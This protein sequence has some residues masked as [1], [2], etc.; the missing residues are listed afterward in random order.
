MQMCACLKDHIRVDYVF[1]ALC[2][3]CARSA[4]S[5]NRQDRNWQSMQRVQNTSV[6]WHWSVF[7][8]S[9]TNVVFQT[10]IFLIL[11]VRNNKRSSG[12]DGKTSDCLSRNCLYHCYLELRFCFNCSLHRLNLWLLFF[13]WFPHGKSAACKKLPD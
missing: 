11:V 4:V 12:I 2:M 13:R 8:C 7:K 9:D 1:C 6:N 5:W 3:V 10:A